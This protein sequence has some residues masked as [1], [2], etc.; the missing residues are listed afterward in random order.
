MSRAT[1]CL[2]SF[3]LL[4]LAA[5]GGVRGTNDSDPVGVSEE[6]AMLA[7]AVL[8][9]CWPCLVAPDTANPAIVDPAIGREKQWLSD[10]YVWLD[11]AVE[12]R[13][14]L[15]V[16]LPGQSNAGPANTPA[17]FKYLAQ[18]A[19]RLGY[20]VIVLTYANTVGVGGGAASVC[21]WTTY[22]KTAELCQENTR[23]EVLDGKA[24]GGTPELAVHLVFKGMTDAHAE[25]HGV[26]DRL[27]KLLEHLALERPG[28]KW[29]RF[30][31]GRGPDLAPAWQKIAISGFSY[32]GNEAALIARSYRVH[33][34]TL[35]GS[36]RDGSGTTPNGWV[37]PGETPSKRYY[38][39][40]HDQDPL[41]LLTLSSWDMLG[42][43]NSGPAVFEENIASPYGKTHMLVTDRV[44]A[45]NTFPNAAHH[46][47]VAH[48]DFTPCMQQGS[49]I[50]CAALG[51]G[52][53]LLGEVWR[54]ML[55]AQG[56]EGEDDS[57]DDSS[58]ESRDE[59]D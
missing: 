43:S 18:E 51:A 27:T 28:E 9:P 47:S 14:K 45:P 34:V 50:Q 11:P 48:D 22:D 59:D 15:F 16:H 46:S 2:S 32:G 12:H 10:H 38:G 17:Q 33:R 37:R 20:H 31:Q 49:T 30:L 35:F 1:W 53:P 5:C 24:R 57:R 54:Y 19:A 29:S 40:V 41:Y 4:G 36:P 21:K 13:E 42:M 56:P 23:L 6:R 8:A 55:G 25:A 3:I 44:P 7:G 26:Y 52:P 39:L 58:D